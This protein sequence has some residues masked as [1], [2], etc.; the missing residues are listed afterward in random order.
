MRT[1][2]FCDYD[3]SDVLLDGST[4]RIRAIHP[5]DRQ[6][7]L[8]HFESLS[9]ES[10]YFRFFA[11]KK[12]LSALE[13]TYFTDLDYRNHVALL[14]TLKD[15]GDE[16]IIGVGRYFVGGGHEGSKR[17]AEV[18]FAVLDEYQGHG[19]ATLLLRH[20]LGIARTSGIGEFTANVLG[21]NHKMIEVLV[22]SVF[23][24]HPTL[25]SGTTHLSFQIHA[26]GGHC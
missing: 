9:P 11:P 14:A 17:S 18:A 15:Q 8:K 24:V 20:L 22:S 5:D 13:L 6:R 19:I 3:T 2:D 26:S 10:V 23:E 7:L 12:T 21:G 25:D 1:C 4:I 16:R